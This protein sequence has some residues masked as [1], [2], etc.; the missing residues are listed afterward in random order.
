MH[1]RHCIFYEFQLGN[2]AS[3]AARHICAALGEGAVADR[4]CPDWFKRFREGDT[5]LENRPRSR[6]PLKFDIER[7]K[8]LIEQNVPS[9]AVC[10]ILEKLIN[11]KNGS[12]IN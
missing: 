7:I 5:S 2:N 8:V 6:H 12:H 11:L 10:M 4:T 3:A 9:I 1:V